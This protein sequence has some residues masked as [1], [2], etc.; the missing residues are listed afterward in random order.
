MTTIH[1][2]KE[3]V[4]LANE[5][6]CGRAVGT[7]TIYVSDATCVSCLR[8]CVC[9]TQLALENLIRNTKRRD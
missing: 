2:I 1:Y 4:D 8:Q 7:G 3:N 9:Q 5:T 6:F